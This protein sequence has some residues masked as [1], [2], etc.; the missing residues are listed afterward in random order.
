MFFFRPKAHAGDSELLEALQGELAERRGRALLRHLHTCEPCRLRYDRMAQALRFAQSGSVARPTEGELRLLENS[1]L[2]AALASAVEPEGSRVLRSRS[3]G[4]LAAGAAVGA[5]LVA[6]LL[7]SRSSPWSGSAQRPEEEG[8]APEEWASRGAGTE[9]QA[10]LRLFCGGPQG[11]PRELADGGRCPPGARLTFAAGIARAARPP[12]APPTLT[13]SGQVRLRLRAGAREEEDLGAFPVTGTPGAETALGAAW[14][15]PGQP[16]PGNE[17]V[18]VLAEFESDSDAGP[19][20]LITR[21][22]SIGAPP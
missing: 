13:P 21:W 6:V 8:P 15:V 16:A 14:E 4:I 9:S 20:K 5:M 3:I 2:A 1:H 7:L 18:E 10:V 12:G 19:R 11:A 17:R 22:L